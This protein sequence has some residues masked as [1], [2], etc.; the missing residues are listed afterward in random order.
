MCISSSCWKQQKGAE[1]RARQFSQEKGSR[2][3]RLM[4]HDV[5]LDWGFQRIFSKLE[6]FTQ[7]LQCYFSS[8]A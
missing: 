7:Q 8:K 2:V 3:I 1:K 6:N 4:N 5:V